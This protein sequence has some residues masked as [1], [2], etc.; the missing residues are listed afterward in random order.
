MLEVAIDLLLSSFYVA[1]T[2][3]LENGLINDVYRD[4]SHSSVHDVASA[5]KELLCVDP[6]RF[7]KAT[8]FVPLSGTSQ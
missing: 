7:V 6:N 2:S 4:L 5:L 8:C 1:I 3:D